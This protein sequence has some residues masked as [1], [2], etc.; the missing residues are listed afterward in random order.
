M[1]DIYKD[2]Y[3]CMKEEKGV[4]KFL[5]DDDLHNP[6]A[7]F[8]MKNIPAGETL[9]EL[10]DSYNYTAFIVSGS[11]EIKKETEFEGK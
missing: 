11:V 1:D 10:E 2:L 9:W 3:A 7:F 8:E 4:F 6:S 5:S